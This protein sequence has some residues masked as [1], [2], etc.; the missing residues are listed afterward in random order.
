[1]GILKRAKFVIRDQKKF[2]RLVD[3]LDEHNS[4]LRIT[5]SEVAAWVGTLIM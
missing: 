2:D 1:M 3:E 4:N 5:C